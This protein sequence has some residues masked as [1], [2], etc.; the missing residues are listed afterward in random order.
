MKKA[1]TKSSMTKC[2]KE[3]E[4]SAKKLFKT[5]QLNTNGNA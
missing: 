2:R 5:K 3:E 1:T 4:M